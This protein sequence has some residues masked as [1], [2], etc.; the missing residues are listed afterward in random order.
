MLQSAE[1]RKGREAA[2]RDLE[3]MIG[4]AEKKG[5][6]A[7]GADELQRLPSLYRTAVSSLSVARAIALDRNLI[8]YLEGLA[9]R[10]YFIVYGPRVGVGASLKG[11]L[12]QRVPARGAAQSWTD[13]AFL[14]RHPRGNA[15]RLR[16]W[17]TKA[18]S[19]SLCSRRKALAGGRGA[20]ST[21]DELRTR[22]IFAPW[23]GFVQSFVVFANFLFRNN[24]GVAILT[25]A[26]G[27]AGG[28]PTFVLLLYQGLIFGAFIAL[29]YDRGLFWDFMGWVSIHGVTEFGAII[30]CGAG[31]LAIAKTILAPG[32]YSRLDN[33][34]RRGT[35]GLKP[36]R[37]RGFDVVPRRI[38][39][40]RLSPVDRQ[41]ALALRLRG[42]DGGAVVQLFRL[43]RPEARR[44]PLDLSASTPFLDGARRTKRTI[45][46]P[47]GVTLEIEIAGIGERLLAFVVDL[48]FWALA[49]A[50]L[51]LVFVALCSTARSTA[52]SS[53]R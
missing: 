41:H 30:L 21:A 6:Q 40:G 45:V 31:G 25:F 29:H 44:W 18:R 32:Q 23:P 14:F 47:E 7:L 10:A 52:P 24:T 33:L 22:E 11:F 36:R 26:L 9:L 17:R 42:G 8:L 13:H 50:F 49:M 5:V 37:R 2:W 12:L 4:V 53:R 39:R 3:R 38:D 16:A 48:C 51:V 43:R 27:V 28:A 15:R 34:A 1:F 35:G 46:T 19:G 20:H